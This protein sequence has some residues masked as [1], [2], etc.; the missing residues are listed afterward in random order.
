M[1]KGGAGNDS[2]AYVSLADSTVALAGKDTVIDFTT[3]DKIDLSAI[4]ADGNEGNGD[5]AFTFGTGAFTGAGEIRVLAFANNRYGVYVETTGDQTPESII[6]VYSDHALTA[7][8]FV[9]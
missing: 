2:F 4:D 6:N 5:T 1:L 3:G 9:L 7:A 8:D